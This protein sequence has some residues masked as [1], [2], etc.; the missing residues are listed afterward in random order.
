[1]A[2]VSVSCAH[3]ERPVPRARIRAGELASFCCEGCRSVRELLQTHG[4]ESYYSQNRESRD[5]GFV[6]GLFE[7]ESLDDFSALDSPDFLSEARVAPERPSLDFYLN[8][9][10]CTACLWLIEQLPKLEPGVVSA[11]LD[12]ARSTVHLELHPGASFARA[13]R[14]LCRLGY[15]PQ[16]ILGSRELLELERADDRRMI[17]RLAV[18]GA[19]AG[20]VMLFSAALYSGVDGGLA[21]LFRWL[22]LAVAVPAFTYAAFP[23]YRSAW[24]SF[25]ARTISIDVPVVLALVAGFAASAVNAVR[26]S[27]E[28]YL[29]SLVGLIFLLLGSRYFLRRLQ[30]SQ[31]SASGLL[32]ALSP[33]RVQRI[34]PASGSSETVRP[35][36]LQVGDLVRIGANEVIPADGEVV[37]GSGQIDCSLLTGESEPMAARPGLPVHAGTRNLEGEL[38]IR[39]MI[40]SEESRLGRIIRE[41]HRFEGARTP[42]TRAA[43]RL[44]RVFTIGVL[45]LACAIIA[46]H[47]SSDPAEGFRRALSMVIVACPCALALATPLTI[48]AAIRTAARD[49]ILVKSSEVLEAA[50]AVRDI[51]LDKTGTL[52]SGT[53]E[54]VSWKVMARE[55]GAHVSRAEVES[56]AYSLE[57]RSR[58]PIARGMVRFLQNRE[59]VDFREIDGFEE[60]AGI[61]VRGSL[62]S[63]RYEICRL[64]GAEARTTTSIAVLRDGICVA[65]AELRDRARP[66][67]ARFVQKLR[68]SGYRIHVLSGDCEGAVR[69]IA[70]EL[71]LTD[72]EAMSRV[73]PEGKASLVGATPGA[74]MV[75]DGANDVLALA[76]ARV[77]VAVGG[78]L[79]ISLRAADVTLTRPGLAPVG[80]FLEIARETRK[81]LYRNF[82]FSLVYNA[83]AATLAVLGII[84]PLAAAVIM[85]ASA[86][87]IFVSST[88]GTS[89]LRG[90]KVRT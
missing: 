72:A 79:E 20:N 4:L 58:H 2:P 67:A 22:T 38:V 85:P 32:S 13:C 50:A 43:D 74:M 23:F 19:C 69:M 8:G 78:G 42:I 5:P 62:A 51:F 18:A 70:D 75:G 71:G 55:P 66:D 3:C 90:A 73:S 68:D 40:P 25:T 37:S 76:R 53:P 24:A 48:G 10:H 41:L 28:I 1:M 89:R 21:T 84:G 87:T 7:Q 61:G 35:G 9:V 44:A 56:A 52:T 80:R 65:Q 36:D 15:P 29:D 34:V 63:H 16:P 60:L 31:L 14:M 11:R 26:G 46:W 88:L 47:W 64:H 33:I 49:G 83:I 17:Q 77:G 82:A 12:L 57:A 39:V 54:V 30:R 45:V 86:L 81:V 59:G 6:P 27:N